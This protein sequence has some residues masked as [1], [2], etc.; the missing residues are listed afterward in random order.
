M[1][2]ALDLASYVTVIV[3]FSGG[4]IESRAMSPD[5]T[6]TVQINPLTWMLRAGA[7]GSGS[8]PS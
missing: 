7:F 5:R 4:E 6:E 2:D 3:A 1:P 8:G